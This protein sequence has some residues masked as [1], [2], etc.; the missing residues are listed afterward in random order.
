MSLTF[1]NVQGDIH[2][3]MVDP[4][5]LRPSAPSG[6]Q[7][8]RKRKTA[9]QFVEEPFVRKRH[10]INWDRVSELLDEIGQGYSPAKIAELRKQLEPR[11]KAHKARREFKKMYMRKYRETY[12]EEQKRKRR[13][14]AKMY[15]RSHRK[16]YAE[17]AR[18]R[19]EKKREADM[20]DG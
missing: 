14:Y 10:K 4:S 8:G 15:N 17:L 19:R 6:C 9:E 12:T 1:D 3:A 5:S 20:A 7:R 11:I 16:H 2:W 13:E 18:A